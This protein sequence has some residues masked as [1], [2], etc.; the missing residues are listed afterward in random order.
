MTKITYSQA[1][2]GFL[3]DQR[4][5]QLSPNTIRDYTNSLTKFAD[6]IGDDPPLR[7]ITVDRVREFL[8]YLGETPQELPG[9][10]PRPPRKLSQKTILNIHTGLSAMWT[11]AVQEGYADRHIIR[12][13]KRPRPEKKEID[14]YTEQDIQAMMDA[15]RR[16]RSYKR[17]GK[18]SCDNT[19]PTALRDRAII[20]LLLD[21]GMRASELCNLIM[22]NVNTRNGQVKVMGKGKKERILPLSPETTKALWSYIAE[23]RQDAL[24]TDTLFL[25]KDG[26]RLSRHGLLRLVQRLGRR[27]GVSGAHPHRF[28]HTF[29]IQFLRNGGDIYA[30]QRSL[31]HET[32]EMV[33]RYL[34][35]VRAD[36]EAAHRIASPVA[37][38][39]KL[40]W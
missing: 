21:T 3:L 13:V 23:H 19:R 5:R 14:P 37:N 2:E 29:A 6:F 34:K 25:N 12:Q 15:C 26:A 38:M 20:L 31:G 17:R 35:I 39:K 10:A 1:V 33:S 22:E 4:A 18:R 28:R 30:L 24:P 8:A 11:W 16:T 27:G 36:V 40:R 32:L 9:I 7:E